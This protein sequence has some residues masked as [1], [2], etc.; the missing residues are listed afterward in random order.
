MDHKKQHGVPSCI[1][2][3][4]S[5][6]Q[7]PCGSGTWVTWEASYP[8][9]FALAFHVFPL[10]ELLFF[11]CSYGVAV[12]HIQSLLRSHFFREDQPLLTDGI[13][14]YLSPSLLDMCIHSSTY[15]NAALIHLLIIS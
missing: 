11:S 1:S 7:A 15:D 2:D 12:S 10:P 8:R 4:V 13:C 9:T 6:T 5:S 3:L 14:P